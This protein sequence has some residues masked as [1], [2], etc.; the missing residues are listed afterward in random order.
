MFC[1][2]PLKNVLLFNIAALVCSEVSAG[3]VIT[4]TRLI[5]PADKN[6]ITVSLNNH[7]ALPVLTQSWVDTGSIDSTPTSSKAPFLISPPVARIDPAKGQSLR[8]L[9]N[10]SP[11][12]Q[13]KESV[14]W[15][16]VLE[17]PPKPQGGNAENSLQMAFRSRIKLFYRPTGL[18]GSAS[19]AIELVQWQLVPSGTGKGFALQA[20]NPSA[21]HVSLVELNLVV[22]KRYDRSEDGMVAPGETRQFSLPTLDGRP[23]AVAQVEFNAINDYGALVPIRKTLQP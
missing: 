11:V 8:L 13:D 23:T 5:Y 1:K 19:E 7:G 18:P 15:L 20:F 16:N 21:Y 17:I 10:G 2:R 12:P 4:G 9:F 14:F 3:V 22:G 6:E